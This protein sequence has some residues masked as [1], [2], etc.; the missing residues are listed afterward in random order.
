MPKPGKL[1]IISL[2]LL[3]AMLMV[4]FQVQAAFNQ[5]RQGEGT[6][7]LAR[8]PPPTSP[9]GATPTST[10]RG[11]PTATATS[12]AGLTPTATST[13]RG[14]PTATPTS[15]A[16]TSTPTSGPSLTPTQTATSRGNPTATATLAAPTSTPTSGP[17]P[18][19]TQTPSGAALPP[20]DL[21]GYRRGPGD[22]VS[23]SGSW[24]DGDH[25]WQGNRRFS[26]WRW[27]G[28]FLR[29]G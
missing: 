14:N 21:Y 6:V 7:L 10:P 9:G 24:P 12:G 25:L 11:N 17:S 20:G 2:A 18:T 16:P 4:S 23:L 19:A 26:G 29:P 27:A 5:G 3:G 8:T 28:R 13:P 22:G 15:G 1:L